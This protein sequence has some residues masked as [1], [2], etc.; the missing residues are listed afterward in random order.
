MHA[1]RRA[2]A[3]RAGRTL[4]RESLISGLESIRDLNLGGFEVSYSP[5]DHAGSRYTDLTIIGRG[6]R[7][8]R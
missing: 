8:M 1:N 6:G 5:R 7:F 2:G 3:R 4:T